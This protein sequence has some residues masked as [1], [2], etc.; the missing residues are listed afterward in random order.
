ESLSARGYSRLHLLCGESLCSDTALWLR[1]ATTALV[2]A[3]IDAG[4]RP[5]EGVELAGP[6]RALHAFALDRGCRLGA[7]RREGAPISAIEIQRHYL[8]RAEACLREAFMPAWA[9]EACARWR[10]MLERLEADPSG[11]SRTLDWAIK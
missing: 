9:G 4:K 3:M 2:V 7:A 1:V 8:G 6:L 10:E 5:A 11:L